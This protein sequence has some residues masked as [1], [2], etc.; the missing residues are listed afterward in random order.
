MKILQVVESLAPRY[1]GPSVACP[2]MCRELA[3]RGHEVAIYATDVDG[4]TRLSV[5]LDHSINDAGVRMH[6]FR[7]WTIP[8][9]YKFSPRLAQALEDTLPSF[10][11]AHIYS[12]YGFPS[13]AAAHYCRKFGVP[14]LLHPHGSL[15]PFL[16]RHHSLRK[17]I[18]SRIFLPQVFS[19]ASAVLFNSEEER[20]LSRGA[21]ELARLDDPFGEGPR[22]VI[23]DVGVEDVFFTETDANARRKFRRKFPELIGRRLVTYFG[24]L[25]F[26]KGLDIL[27]AAFSAVAREQEGIHLVLAGP[28]GEGYGAQVRSWLAHEGMLPRATFIG[29]VAGAERVALL[30]DSEMMVLPSYTENFGQAV[31]EAMAAGTAVI[32]SDGVNIWPEVEKAR[33]GIVVACDAGQTAEALRRLL[34]DPAGTREMGRRGRELASARF[35]WSAVGEQILRVYETMLDRQGR[36]QV[37]VAAKRAAAAG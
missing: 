13:L 34:A 28:D 16:R 2:A 3:R 5:P 20:R 31:A 32:I 6:Y 29:N 27:V 22:S 14:F 37:R 23:V 7:G 9:R 30:Q 25:N 1:G 33:A 11:L 8:P 19:G 21:P 4:H 15:D 18:Y 35:P 26:K 24:R 12:I 36:R 17:S 10:D